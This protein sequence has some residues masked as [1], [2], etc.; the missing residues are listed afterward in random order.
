MSQSLT[1][2]GLLA[3]VS[4]S[5][6]L[7]GAASPQG[8]VPKPKSPIPAGIGEFV[9]YT[10]PVTEN[11]L[12]R[13]TSPASSSLLPEATNR[14]ISLRG[15]FLVF[16]SDR[17]GHLNPFRADLRTGALAQIADTQSLRPGSLCLDE[18]E[19]LL[20][21]IEGD[22]LV[23]M[24]L[25]G[26][27][28]RVL[29]DGV[30]AFSEVREPSE[31]VVVRGKRLEYLSRSGPVLAEEVADWCLVSPSAGA[32]LFGRALSSTESE[33][34]YTGLEPDRTKKPVKIA[35][36]NI[37]NPRWS[38]NGRSVLFLRH[39]SAEGSIISNL[40]E[41]S[42]ESLLETE[43]ART[44][45]F[46]VFN[47]NDEATVFLGA[48]RS[49]AQPN[50]ILLLRSPGR[51]LTLCEHRAHDPKTVTPVFSPDGRRIYF[52]SDREGKSALYSMNVEAIVEPSSRSN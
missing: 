52:Q 31:F 1:R 51:E 39:S 28:L 47:A 42:L 36:G 13:L 16:S 48:S 30:S 24:N 23:E 8:K 29:A 22:R 19:R 20:R 43:V 7:C 18:Q 35:S 21:F 32:C 17:N 44:S 12:V 4:A 10:D 33:F 49:K 5:V 3:G 2:R 50:I 14:F 27:K 34:W 40:R 37:S 9:R 45:Q 11:T 46:A 41:V 38:P 25:L 15:R 6:G 26:R